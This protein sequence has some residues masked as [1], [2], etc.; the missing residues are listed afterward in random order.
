VNVDPK[1]MIGGVPI[2]RVRDFFRRAGDVN[3]SLEWPSHMLKL[4]RTR[5]LK[6]IRTLQ[7]DSYVEP[8]GNNEFPWRCTKKG[9]ALASA[10]GTRP[11][12]RDVAQAHLERFLQRVS[13]ANHNPDFVYRVRRVFLFGSFLTTERERVGDLDLAVELEPCE[14]DHDRQ[15]A[16]HQ[17]RI[18]AALRTGRHFSNYVEQVYWPKLEIMRFLR[19][20]SRAVSLHSAEEIVGQGWPMKV[21]YEASAA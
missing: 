21:I 14:S 11:I 4:P 3:W 7:K 16:L 18:S 20:R 9:L 2:L 6:L 8:S 17:Q 13:L 1:V 19:Q 15:W 5:T 10:L 12:G